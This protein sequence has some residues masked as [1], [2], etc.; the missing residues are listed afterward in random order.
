MYDRHLEFCLVNDETPMERF[1]VKAN[2]TKAFEGKLKVQTPV[3]TKMGAIVYS[4]DISDEC[5]H[6]CDILTL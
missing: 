6:H 3:G 4:V 1:S 2:L 5:V